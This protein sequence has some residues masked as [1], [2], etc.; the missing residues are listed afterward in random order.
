[1]HGIYD[2]KRFT[3]VYYSFISTDLNFHQKVLSGKKNFTEKYTI[4]CDYLNPK[5]LIPCPLKSCGGG[6]VCAGGALA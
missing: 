2:F 5:L 4:Q 3:L 1:M 6:A